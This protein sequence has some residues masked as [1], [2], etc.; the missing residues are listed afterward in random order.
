MD[1][2]DLHVSVP[3]VP[4]GELA[5]GR[6]GEPS[7]A[8]RERVV[9][10]RALQAARF[11]GAPGVLCNAHMGAAELR[12]H[13]RPSPDVLA[14]LQRAI[15]RLGL[16]ARAYHRLLKVARTI[17]DLE[18][19]ERVRTVHAAEAIQYRTLDRPPC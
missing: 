9:G 8:V 16:S 1:R 7:A 19:C 11:A 17:A 6:G 15:D 18:G 10:A 14:L 3:S 5:S 4:F 2:I 12:R 13:V